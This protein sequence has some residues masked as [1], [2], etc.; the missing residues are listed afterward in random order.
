[1]PFFCEADNL[2]PYFIDVDKRCAEI[3]SLFITFIQQYFHIN[4]IENSRLTN[5]VI[6]NIYIEKKR[7]KQHVQCV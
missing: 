2:N 4:K 5:L 3:P 6:S 7:N 1:M